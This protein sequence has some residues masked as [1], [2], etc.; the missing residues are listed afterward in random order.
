MMVSIIVISYNALEY[1]KI[2]LNS[3][4]EK[5]AYP[6]ELI[7]IDNNS[8]DGTIQW[9]EGQ[10]DHFRSSISKYQFV[11]NLKNVG[12]SRAC[13]QGIKLAEGNYF[14]FLN[15]DLMLGRNWLKRLISHLSKDPLAGIVGPLGKAIG[16]EQNYV[17]IYRDY[18]YRKPE[19]GLD[20]FNDKL[21]S[22]FCGDYT[23]T[24][25]L[26]GCCLLMKREVVE[27]VGLFD[28]EL[29]M[30]ADDFDY[31]LRARMAGYKL[32]IA[33]DVLIHHYD[34]QSF[35]M[36][37]REEEKKFITE[38]WQA[39]CNKWDYILKNHCMDD[40]FYNKKKLFYSGLVKGR[41]SRFY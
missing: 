3:I 10:V 4:L 11:K 1:L 27:K 9:L 24:K 33:E 13:N 34:H 25:F 6:F 2:T 17:H 22:Q 36:L 40:L 31:S 14:A 32:Y 8:L 35:K 37:P 20:I 30:S 28:P 29:Y 23:E 26:I 7:I 16:G 18:A 19:E 15:C 39:F 21:Y 41:R 5:T 12:Y 38:G